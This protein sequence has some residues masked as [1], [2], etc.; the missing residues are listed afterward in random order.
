VLDALNEA[1]V[2]I[3]ELLRELSGDAPVIL[4][5][6]ELLKIVSTI[7]GATTYGVVQGAPIPSF[8]NQFNPTGPFKF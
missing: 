7:P 8:L 1:G 2:G 5:P 6:A 3:Q 4:T